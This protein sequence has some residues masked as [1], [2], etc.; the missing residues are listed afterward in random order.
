MP[1]SSAMPAIAP[2]ARYWARASRFGMAA[3][4][5]SAVPPASVA[6][7]RPT[8]ARLLL[9]GPGGQRAWTSDRPAGE[10]EQECGD[11]P[12]ARP[13]APKRPDLGSAPSTRRAIRCPVPVRAQLR[14]GCAGFARR[15]PRDVETALAQGDIA[16][17][18]RAAFTHLQQARSGWPQVNHARTW[19]PPR[20]ARPRRG[21]ARACRDDPRSRARRR[22]RR[23]RA[24]RACRSRRRPDRIGCAK[25]GEDFHRFGPG[26]GRITIALRHR[27]CPA[28]RGR[29]VGAAGTGH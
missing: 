20:S 6:R 5:R 18:G 15:R 29:Q 17:L 28:Q 12:L 22:A 21:A 11:A 9:D 10:H 25:P 2:V 4:R 3:W 13:R 24:A 19:A 16:A 26:H 23:A 27:C 7:V 8:P 14:G 1:R